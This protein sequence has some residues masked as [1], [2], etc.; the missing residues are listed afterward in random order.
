MFKMIPIILKIIPAL[1][2]LF[3]P[4]FDWERLNVNPARPRIIPPTGPRRNKIET[5]K[6]MLNIPKITAASPQLLSAS[7]AM[8][9]LRRRVL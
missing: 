1:D 2:H 4:D 8:R 6:T 3:F 7:F 5:P 9:V